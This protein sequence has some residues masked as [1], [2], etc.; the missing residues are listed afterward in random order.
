VEQQLGQERSFAPS[1]KREQTIAVADL[2]LA[3]D[4]VLHCP[5]SFD[6]STVS[7]RFSLRL[8]GI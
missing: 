2:D 8:D 6:L 1:A 7:R 5:P 3:Q 4:P